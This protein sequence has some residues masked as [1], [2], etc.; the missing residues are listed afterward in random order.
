MPPRSAPGLVG[1]R[2][3]R[4]AVAELPHVNVH[5]LPFGAGAHPAMDGAFSIMG[6]PE[7]PDPDVVYP[8]PR[9]PGPG[10]SPRVL[11]WLDCRPIV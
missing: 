10:R 2:A 7:A 3:P 8:P 4:S 11:V 1:P 6:F 9:R 5:V